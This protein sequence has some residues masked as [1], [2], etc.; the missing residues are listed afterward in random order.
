MKDNAGKTLSDAVEAWIQIHHQKKSGQT[1]GKIA[2]QFQYNQYMRDFLADNPSRTPA[3][4]RHCWNK[5]KQFKAPHRY[6]PG[7]LTFL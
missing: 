7:D 4:A 2:P 5:K 1:P 6:E 3:D